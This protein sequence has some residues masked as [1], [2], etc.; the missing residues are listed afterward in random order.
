MLPVAEMF[1]AKVPRYTSYP[2]AP[3]FHTGIDA[4]TYSEWLRSI[5]QDT[6]LS[7][8]L[9]I[10]FCDTL[11]W[12]CGCHTTAVTIYKPVI[13]YCDLLLREMAL[14]SRALH[15]RYRVSHI[16]WGG[17]SPTMLRIPEIHR[18]NEATG[19][20]FDIAPNADFG[21]EIDPRGLEP[22]TVQALKAAGVTRASIGLQDCDPKVQRAINRMQSNEETTRAVSLL[23]D[24]GIASLNIDLV[25]GLPHQSLQSWEATLH[26][27][28]WLNPDRLAVFGYAHIPQFKKHQAL[29]PESALPGIE[30]RFA[31]AELAQHVLCA[32]GYVAVGLDHFAKPRDPLAQAAASGNMTRNFQGYSTDRASALIGLG[33][34]AIGSLPSGYVQ[35]LAT[36]PSYR[37]ALSRGEMPI[38]RG[39]ALSKEDRLRRAIIERLMCQLEVDLDQVSTDF[40]MSDADFSDALESLAPMVRDGVISFDRSRLIISPA[41]RSATRLVCAAFD[42]Y[43]GRSPARHS[44]SI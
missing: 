23:R 33:A 7:L 44:V 25:Y 43:L 14:V 20:Q 27:A 29:I 30:L 26:F 24:A 17:G 6:S 39:V 13:D 38:A 36:V 9:H 4:G 2:T 32:H 19:T 15:A 31:L 28:L 35:N 18:I 37:A 42:Q 12:F 40:G 34:S 3:H 5:P 21:I 1:S 10:P 8:Y 11:C 16:H 41:W 22:G